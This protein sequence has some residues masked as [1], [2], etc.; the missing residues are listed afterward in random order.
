MQHFR[1]NPHNKKLV[2]PDVLSRYKLYL[3]LFYI[4]L[5]NVSLSHTD[6]TV[7]YCKVQLYFIF[8][9]VQNLVFLAEER[10]RSKRENGAGLMR[11][12]CGPNKYYVKET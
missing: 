4:I 9:R 12:I 5:K 11:V 6:T 3:R 1:Y 10:I 2:A 7:T 8:N